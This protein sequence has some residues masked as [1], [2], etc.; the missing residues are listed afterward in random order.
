MAQGISG[1]RAD[2]DM[3]GGIRYTTGNGE[4][5]EE[6]ALAGERPMVAVARRSGEIA[7]V[8]VQHREHA[9]YGSER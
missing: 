7:G 3:M 8:E 9:F 4:M 1:A 2:P 5:F 6:R